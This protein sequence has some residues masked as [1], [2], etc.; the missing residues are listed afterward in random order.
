MDQNSRLGIK[1]YYQKSRIDNRAPLGKAI[2]YLVKARRCLN[3]KTLHK[4]YLADLY[5]LIQ[6]FFIVGKYHITTALL[7]EYKCWACEECL[8][9]GYAMHDC[10]Q[11][12][13]LQCQSNVIL[14]KL[15]FKITSKFVILNFLD[16]IL[17]FLE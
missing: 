5:S 16:L 7:N 4:I 3:F 11:E 2:Q 13:Y 12:I 17:I 9:Q 1:T 8:P 6:R 15:S 14:M 10:E